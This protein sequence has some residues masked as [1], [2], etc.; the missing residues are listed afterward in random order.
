MGAATRSDEFVGA[1]SSRPI[2]REPLSSSGLKAL[3]NFVDTAVPALLLLTLMASEQNS[4]TVP[5]LKRLAAMLSEWQDLAGIGP[6]GSD[7]TPSAVSRLYR[8]V[9][10]LKSQTGRPGDA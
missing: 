8:A 5:D 4:E 9:N 10:S 7:P 6:D 2:G 3:T 1:S